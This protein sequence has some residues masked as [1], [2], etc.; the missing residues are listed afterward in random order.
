MGLMLDSAVF[1]TE[2]RAGKNVYQVIEDLERRFPGGACALS[3]ITLA[4]L[5]PGAMRANTPAHKS[6]RERFLRDLAK[7]MPVYPVTASIA[8]AAGRM[9]GSLAAKGFHVGLPDLLIGATALELGLAVATHNHCHFRLIPGLT[10]VA[11]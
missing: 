4:E 9:Q 10:V 8:L 3:V 6:T 2:E 11:L 7:A 1:I 5:A